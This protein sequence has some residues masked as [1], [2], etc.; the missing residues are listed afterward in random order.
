MTT[1]LEASAAITAAL[2]AVP[3]LTVFAGGVPDDQDMPRDTAGRAKPYAVVYIGAGRTSSDRHG[4]MRPA[5]AAPL[6]LSIPLQVTAAAGTYEGALWAAGK[7][8]AA[9]TGVPLLDDAATTRL[10]EDADAGRAQ[11]DKSVPSD[12]RWYLPMQYRFTTTT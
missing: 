9:L 2:E 3:N 4:G 12:V 5:A 7:V 8:R 10:R 6:N 1:I 11:E